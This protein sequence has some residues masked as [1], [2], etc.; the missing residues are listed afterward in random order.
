MVDRIRAGVLR[1]DVDRHEV[2]DR[3]GGGE[4]G[5]GRGVPS[6][7]GGEARSQLRALTVAQPAL[8]RRV[9]HE[10]I[11]RRA[12]AFGARIARGEGTIRRRLNPVRAQGVV[13]LPRGVQGDVDDYGDEGAARGSAQDLGVAPTLHR[14]RLPEGEVATHRLEGA[15]FAAGGEKEHTADEAQTRGQTH[16]K[17]F[18]RDGATEQRWGG[19]A[20]TG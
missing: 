17:T 9:S 20:G 12:V 8:E 4:R 5:D 11:R 19:P 2:A 7:C 18:G 16:A 13:R 6:T 15:V 1:V 14:Q 10:G 3:D